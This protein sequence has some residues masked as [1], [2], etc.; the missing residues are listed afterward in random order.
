MITPD[1]N[2]TPE[3]KNV[4]NS[5]SQR[6]HVS[7]YGHDQHQDIETNDKQQIESPNPSPTRSR[8][9]SPLS[10]AYRCNTV[11]NMF[12]SPFIF[13]STCTCMYILF[14]LIYMIII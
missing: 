2:S 1:D 12:N 13:H 3:S 5:F 9:S 7:P 10:P 8:E 6:R 11:R 4:L 14:I